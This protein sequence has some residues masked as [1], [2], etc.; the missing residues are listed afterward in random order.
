MSD[1]PTAPETGDTTTK[2]RKN[3]RVTPA[4]RAVDAETAK[5]MGFVSA[6]ADSTDSVDVGKAYRF[7]NL[8][9]VPGMPP[10]IPKSKEFDINGEEGVLPVPFAPGA[11]ILGGGSGTGKSLTA[12]ALFRRFAE[13]RESA[14]KRAVDPTV[15]PDMQDFIRTTVEYNMRG[16]YFNVFEPT[17]Q[18]AFRFSTGD[19]VPAS[20]AKFSKADMFYEADLFL[21]ALRE[22]KSE[23]AISNYRD[24]AR[25]ADLLVLLDKMGS[26][27]TSS[28]LNVLVFD[29]LT[30]PC[31]VYKSR[32]RS[33]SRTFKGGGQPADADF[34]RMLNRVCVSRNVLLFAV[35][36]TDVLPVSLSFEGV[37]EGIALINAP[38]RMALKSRAGGRERLSINLAADLID[39]AAQDFGYP[40]RKRRGSF[41]DDFGA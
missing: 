19:N 28:P 26:T 30:E 8:T 39:G 9:A 29:S 13:L 20:A 11:I 25:E 38:G 15:R 37:T 21:Q 36:N 4:T 24:A 1:K 22:A 3:K 10:S 23:T 18:L 5:T 31:M 32:D 2:K 17:S 7:G 33:G 12:L 6:G 27:D 41:S 35:I 40:S 34:F 16:A 14:R